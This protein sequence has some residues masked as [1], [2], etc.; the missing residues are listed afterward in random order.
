MSNHFPLA[1]FLVKQG[2]DVLAFD[3]EGYG[4]SEGKPTPKNLVDDGI[5]T[6]R[7]AQAHLREPGT[8]VGV[9]GQS[10][11]GATAI[12]TTAEEPL[13]KAAVIEA[14]FTSYRAMGRDVVGRHVLT[15]PLYSMSPFLENHYDAIDFVGKISPRPVLFIHGDQDHTVPVEM[16]RQLFAAAGE[17]KT[18][19]IIKGADHLQCRQTAGKEYE[20]KIAEFFAAALQVHQ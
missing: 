2:F 1:V 6:V 13:V 18:L 7:Y 19:W 20:T 17:P 4:A 12:V 10:L 14:A 16:S 9:F 5:A 8:G 11:G 15:W 3:Y